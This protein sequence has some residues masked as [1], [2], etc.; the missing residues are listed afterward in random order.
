MFR[1]HYFQRRGLR[2]WTHVTGVLKRASCVFTRSINQPGAPLKHPGRKF[3]V[4][5]VYR[6][7]G[8][9]LVGRTI[10][11][12]RGETGP[13]SRTLDLARNKKETE[14]L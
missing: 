4:H 14:R 13:N 11:I 6:P 9:S 3:S 1:P 2:P 7:Q 12:R 5:V 10:R 8:A